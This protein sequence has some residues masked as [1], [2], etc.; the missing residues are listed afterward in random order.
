VLMIK[1]GKMKKN[2]IFRFPILDS[3][4][5]TVLEHEYDMS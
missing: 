4:V 5:S 2:Q 1:F 3:P